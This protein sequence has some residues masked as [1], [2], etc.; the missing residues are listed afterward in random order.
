MTK[1]NIFVTISR[2]SV[3]TETDGDG[4]YRKPQ[5]VWMISVE[6]LHAH[7][8]FLARARQ[9]PVQYFASGNPG[10]RKVSAAQDIIGSILVA[11]EAHSSGDEIFGLLRD[12][13]SAKSTS[14][15]TDEANGIS[16][17]EWIRK[18]LHV[19]QEQKLTHA[20]DV[21]EFITFAH[22]YLANRADNEAPA[23]IPY[24]ASQLEK[25]AKNRGFWLSYPTSTT[26]KAADQESRRYGGL[27]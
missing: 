20:F 22:G 27:M 15:R 17:E 19:L 12:K 6:P 5:H 4:H 3:D 13:L 10:V 7:L 2:Q 24:S 18:V 11:Q 9:A 16:D 1:S 14:D 26:K 8:S 25:K 21:G 23:M